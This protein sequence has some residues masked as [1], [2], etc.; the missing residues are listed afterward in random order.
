MVFLMFCPACANMLAL[1]K[2]ASRGTDEALMRL[3]CG[4][5]DYEYEMDRTISQDV[6]LEKKDVDDVLGSEEMWAT[7]AKTQAMC[8]RC[9]HDEAYL[10]EFQ[11]R[12]ADEPTTR[13]HR[14]TKCHHAWK[15]D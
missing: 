2:A 8:P 11:T 7:A 10:K 13:Y 9:H 12:S 14:C 1:K 5:C 3:Y 15:E 4:S 6:P